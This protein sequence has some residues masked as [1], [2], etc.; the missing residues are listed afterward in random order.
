[1]DGEDDDFYANGNGDDTKHQ[2]MD[3]GDDLKEEDGLEE[4]EEEEDSDDDSVS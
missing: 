3:F 4:G 2:D 1:M